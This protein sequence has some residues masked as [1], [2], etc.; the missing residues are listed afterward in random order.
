G[1]AY[2]PHT[3]AYDGAVWNGYV[4]SNR[5]DMTTPGFENQYSAYIAGGENNTSGN[6]YAIY[7]CFSGANIILD[8]ESSVSG[9]W[10]TNTTYAYLTMLAGDAYGICTPFGGNDGNDQDWF[11]F[12]ATGITADG[13]YV[14]K[15]VDFY[16]ADF[17]S[18]DNTEDY[19]VDSWTWLDLS[20]LGAIKEIEFSF[21]SS[22]TGDWG[23]NTPTYFAF[24]NFNGS[25][26]E[27]PAVPEPVTM[28]LLA[29]GVVMV[30][31]RMKKSS[32]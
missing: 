2:Y 19:I 32:R 18:D 4:Y 22:D 12:T 16:L 30:S 3:T 31:R 14:E 25:P 11:K 9:M 5:T 21:A 1:V 17:R 7:Y 6:Q 13:S 15:A 23:I 24:D 20:S 10:V 28:A 8:Q 27:A 26:F 29:G